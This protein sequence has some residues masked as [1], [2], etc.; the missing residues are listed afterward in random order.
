MLVI[1]NINTGTTLI[2]KTIVN[3]I[4]CNKSVSIGINCRK[5][6]LKFFPMTNITLDHHV[7]RLSQDTTCINFQ[8]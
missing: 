6:F 2:S 1:C 3:E 5:N 8:F 7:M 4:E